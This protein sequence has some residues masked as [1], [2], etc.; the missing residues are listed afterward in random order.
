MLSA[1]PARPQDQVTLAN[2]RTPPFNRW[3]F[4]HVREIVPTAEIA[5]DPERRWDFPRALVDLWEERF[6]VAGKERSVAQWLQESQTDGLIVL[7]QGAIVAERYDNHLTP[8]TP[9]IVFSVTKSVTAL[10]LGILAD[11]GLL[12]PDAPVTRYIPEAK[13]SGYGDA[14]VRH[15]LDMQVSL[16]FDEVY[17]ATEGPFIRYRESTGWNVVADPSKAS[18]LRSFLVSLGRREGPHGKRFRY[19]SPNSDLLG[20]ICERAAGRRYADLLSE[21]LWQPMGAER[22]ANLTVD[23]LGAPRSAG[24]LCVTLRDLARLGELVRCRGMADGRTVVPGW[25]IDDI[26]SQGDPAAWDGSEFEAMLPPEGR[27]RSQWYLSDGRGSQAMAVGIHGQWIWVDRDRGITI[28]K[29]SSQPLPTT[30]GYDPI[31]LGCFEA[32][33]S[34]L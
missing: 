23:R 19:L 24:G 31:E 12:D 29:L 33:A 3:S 10:L 8:A 2:W 25:W 15:V 22:P 30:L 7:Q 28:A 9:H 18:D 21:L 6:T 4:Q 32:L 17:L 14:S 13:G 16:D 5:E 1:F 34:A 27:Y 20:W 11:Q 26:L